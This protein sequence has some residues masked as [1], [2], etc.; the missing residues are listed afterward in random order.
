M[1]KSVIILAVAALALVACNNTK[2]EENKEAVPA[3]NQ[4]VVAPEA[5]AEETQAEVPAEAAVEATEAV[6]E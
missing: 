1:K 4:E 2:K 3:E 5:Q 6:N